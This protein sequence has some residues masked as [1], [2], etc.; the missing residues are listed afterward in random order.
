MLEQLEKVPESAS[1]AA[2]LAGGR[3]RQFA[4]HVVPIMKAVYTPGNMIII[5]KYRAAV[6]SVAIEMMK[7][8]TEN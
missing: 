3:G 7:P 2:R 5:E 6:L 8:I 1:A 4:S